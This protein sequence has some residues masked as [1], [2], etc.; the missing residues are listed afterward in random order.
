MKRKL[1]KVFPILLLS[2]LLLSGC[3]SSYEKGAFMDHDYGMVSDSVSSTS[4]SQ[5]FYFDIGGG[6]DMEALVGASLNGSSQSKGNASSNSSYESTT[7]ESVI[8]EDANF[9]NVD[10][11]TQKLI[12][13]AS[14]SMETLDLANTVDGI[15]KEVK[16]LGG[17]ISNSNYND[18]YNKSQ[19]L[20]I[21]IPYNKVD[22]FLDTVGTLGVIKGQ[23]DSVEDIT[24]SYSDTKSRIS[25]LEIEYERLNELLAKA[26]SL[27]T[28]IVLEDRLTQVRYELEAHTSQIKLWDSLILYS[29]INISITQEAYISPVIEDKTIYS[30]IVSGLSD[31]LNDLKESASDFIVE[32]VINLPYLIIWVIIILMIILIAKG[33]SKKRKHKKDKKNEKTEE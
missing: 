15:K 22:D 28:I 14:L 21:R 33:L 5:G 7:N 20:T 2:S 12:R 3:G 8:E 23:S 24:L 27:E 30:R 9:T 16:R 4:N 6:Q 19:N 18:G 13:R 25:S 10:S 29:T 31:T 11:M 1:F 26:D 32:L 17:Y